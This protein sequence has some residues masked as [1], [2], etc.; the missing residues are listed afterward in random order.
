ML[1]VEDDSEDPSKAARQL[2]LNSVI[3]D[4][5]ALAT[6]FSTELKSGKHQ[7]Y[8]PRDRDVIKQIKH[9]TDLESLKKSIDSANF[10]QVSARKGPE[11]IRTIKALTPKLKVAKNPIKKQ[12]TALAA[13]EKQI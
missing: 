6:H 8:H 13:L 2:Q 4:L 12:E 5:K 10:V 9:V 1:S 3:N 7:V 11:Y